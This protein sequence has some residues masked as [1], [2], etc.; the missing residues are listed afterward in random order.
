MRLTDRPLRPLFPKGMRSDIQVIITTLSA[1]QEHDPQHLAIIGAS[2]ALSISDIPFGGPVSAT[3]IGFIGGKL[4]AN[5]TFQEQQESDLDLM[6]AGTREAVVMVEAGANEVSEE[7]V[8]QGMKMA[9]IV[10]AETIELQEELM[11]AAA[12]P[13]FTV[14]LP[15][16]APEDL[17]DAVAGAAGSALDDVLYKPGRKAERD[18]AVAEVK[19]RVIRRTRRPLRARRGGQAVRSPPQEPGARRAYSAGASAS[20]GA[21]T[22]EIRP[23]TCEVGV[24]PRTHGSGLFTRGETQ[25]LTIT[26]LGSLSL[27]QRLD[28]IGIE[29]T[30]RYM[31]QYNMPPYSTGEA[32]RIGSSGRREIGHGALAERALLPMV[33]DEDEFPYALRVVSEVLS[34][35]GSTSMASVCGSTLSLMDAGVPIKKPVAG[36]AMGLVVGDAPDQVRRPHRH[37]GLGRR[38]RRHGLQGCRHQGRH[39]RPADGPQVHRHYLPRDRAGP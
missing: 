3:R 29:D 37:P 13:K 6:V 39:H 38:P 35:N 8:L 19:K 34:S 30:K 27:K 26:T 32:K 18:A 7:I 14:T 10:N 23:I 5:P 16:P 1:D 36:V 4:V 12:K 11:Q 33:P 24:L 31:H 25:A 2:A 9:Q 22:D 20:T 28:T 21:A 17:A 15:E